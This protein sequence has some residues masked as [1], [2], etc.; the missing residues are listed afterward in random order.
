MDF[1]RLAINMSKLT[2]QALGRLK[3]GQ[4][5]Q[6]EKRYSDRL[7][8]LKRAGE[9]LWYEFEPAN[10][11]LADKC[12]YKVDF[13]VLTKDSALEVHEVK[14]FLTD[15]ALVKIKAAAEKFP[16]KFIMVQYIKKQWEVREF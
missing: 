1:K 4:M 16:F 5:N 13:L 12:F 14:G 2:Y 11:R 8:L 9:I 3:S 6:T 10:L 7:E 15:D